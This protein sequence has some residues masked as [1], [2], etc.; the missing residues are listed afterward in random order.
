[1]SSKS[2]R[3]HDWNSRENYLAIHEQ[4]LNKFVRQCYLSGPAVYSVWNSTPQALEL[5]IKGLVLRRHNGNSVEFKIEK[6]AE[7]DISWARPRVKTFSYSYHAFYPKPLSRNLIRYCSPH[8]HRKVHHKHV[9]GVDGINSA[10]VEVSDR[11]WP[12][13]DEFINEVLESF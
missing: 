5:E 4:I 13:V 7:V 8:E 6:T 10:V 2:R 12:H 9:Y 11:I 3:K 1:M